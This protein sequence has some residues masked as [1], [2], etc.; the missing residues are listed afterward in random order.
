MPE[1]AVTLPPEWLRMIDAILITHPDGMREI[2][3]IDALAER[4]PGTLSR[5]DLTHPMSR[6]RVHFMLFH[7]LYQLRANLIA[8]QVAQLT[9][10]PL[11]IKREPWQSS[12]SHAI[13]TH[14]PLAAYYLDWRNLSQVDVG[15]VM[16]MIGGF[17]QTMAA[18]TD[19]QSALVNDQIIPDN[20]AVPSNI[21]HP[22]IQPTIEASKPFNLDVGI[23]TCSKFQI[24]LARICDRHRTDMKL[25]NEVNQLIKQ[26]SL[27]RQLSFSTDNLSTRLGFIKNIGKSLNTESNIPM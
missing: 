7:A 27:G 20:T 5:A 8:D 2:D 19:I 14:D 26:H 23:P 1:R 10:A 6:F 3:L 25:F 16:A 15:D 4:A 12:G 9:I 21:H 11:S 13:D 24:Q 18:P 22:S 17:W